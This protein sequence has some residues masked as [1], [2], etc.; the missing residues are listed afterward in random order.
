MYRQQDNI[1]IKLP[2][3]GCEDIN[4]IKLLQDKRLIAL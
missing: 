2:E 3:I 4:Q 1:K